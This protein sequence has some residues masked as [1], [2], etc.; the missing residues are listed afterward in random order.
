VIQCSAKSQA[1]SSEEKGSSAE[2]FARYRIGGLQTHQGVASPRSKKRRRRLNS[3]RWRQIETLYDQA[4]EIEESRREAFLRQVCGGDD[5]LLQDLEGLLAKRPRAA[6]FLKEPALRGIAR[7]F[8]ATA[9]AAPSWV[10]REIANYQFVSLLGSGGMGEVY[11]ARDTRLERQVAIKILPEEFSHD[12]DRVS[13]FQREAH[14]L[15]SLNHPNIAAIYGF[16]KSSGQDFLVMELVPGETLA[17]RIKR[18]PLLVDEA[19]GIAKQICEALEAAHEKSIVHRDLK[20][21]NVKITPDGRVK[22][23]DFGLAKAYEPEASNANLSNSPTMA[24]MGTTNAGVILGTASYMSPEQ[25]KGRAVDRRADIFA[26]GCVLY[27]MLTGKPAFDG[28]DIPDILSRVLQREPDWRLLP[29]NVPAAVRTLLELCLEK[30][31]KNRRSDAADIRIDLERASKESTGGSASSRTSAKNQTWLWAATI[32]ASLFAIAAFAVMFRPV[33]DS[34]EMR[35]EINTPITRQPNDFAI[36]PDG[37]SIVF[38]ASGD[39]LPRLWLRRFDKTDAQPLV[40]TEGAELPFWSPENKSVGFFANHKLKRLDITGGPPTTLEDVPRDARGGTWNANGIILFSTGGRATNTYRIPASGGE[41]V[42][43][44]RLG[45]AAGGRFPRF[46]PDGRHFLF[47]VIDPPEQGI[48]IASLDGADTKLL[49]SADG[50]GVF[51]DPDRLLFIRQGVLLSQ[52]FDSRHNELIGDPQIVADRVS[53]DPV[54]HLGGYSVSSNG[55][56]ALRTGGTERRQLTWYDRSGKRMESVGEPD[57][58]VLHSPAISRDGRRLAIDRNV[59]S[60]RDIWIV[61]LIRGTRQPFTSE[62][63]V[64]GY[65]VWSADGTQ[66]F[67]ES[68]R[69]SGDYDLYVKSTT[70]AS[71]ETVLK[72]LPGNQWPLD[73]SR[74]E[75]FLLYFD[76]AN[77]GDLWALPLRDENPKPIPVATSPSNERTGEF[78]RDGRWVAYDTDQSGRFEVMVQSFPDAKDRLQ[79]S[80]AGGT[81]P[82]WSA[83]GKELF[84]IAPDAQLMSVPIRAGSPFDAGTPVPLFPTRIVTGTSAA[85][86]H[87]Y[88]VGMDGRFL[89][90]QAIE[91]SSPS[92][93]ALILNWKQTP[94]QF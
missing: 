65:P 36:S 92:P 56:I 68:N 21:A 18:G 84:F 45:V 58:S 24:S 25:A 57:V 9:T 91:D 54:I 75:R 50:P 94:P 88:V 33:P 53:Y 76:S 85:M 47:Y 82:R 66:M 26:F 73:A 31:P 44:D 90:N 80:T 64:E 20:P 60:S 3:A 74:D 87:Q 19:L 39:G 51:V 71:P 79:V 30:N 32:A 37:Q 52:R 4:L 40:G 72:D 83:D 10:G 86:K 1:N 8:A 13:R 7:E 69:K 61:D 28:E 43:L 2:G 5:E 42:I 46:L 14:L 93:I 59:Q 17:E 35:L 12:T 22:V 77:A 6:S 55:R 48:H 11:R 16:E 29:S 41:S 34:P 70:G 23:L 81:Y 38:V 89:I 15:A 78:S 63:S 27:E 67:F 49:A 62:K